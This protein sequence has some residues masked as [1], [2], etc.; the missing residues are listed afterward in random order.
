MWIA[1]QDKFH[2]PPTD[3]DT[4]DSSINPLVHLFV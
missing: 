1:I 2:P 3:F 4:V